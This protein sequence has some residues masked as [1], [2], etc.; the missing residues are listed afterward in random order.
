MFLCFIHW[1]KF[2]NL[3]ILQGY[4]IWCQKKWDSYPQLD[5]SH[6]V[7]LRQW[8]NLHEILGAQVWCQLRMIPTPSHI[9]WCQ[10]LHPG[11]TSVEN[12]PETL[13]NHSYNSALS[14][15]SQVLWF[16]WVWLSY[17]D[18]FWMVFE[19]ISVWFEFGTKTCPPSFEG[20][21]CLE[22]IDLDLR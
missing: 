4:Y 13:H 9:C 16:G 15:D 21:W 5:F 17:V 19:L 7:T 1:F 20:N 18:A 14:L 22:C 3:S 2:Q 12:S 10:N 6:Q 11:T 8:T